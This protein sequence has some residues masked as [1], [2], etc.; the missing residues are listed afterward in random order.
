MREKEY[1]WNLRNFG[2]GLDEKKTMCRC[3][4]HTIW[5]WYVQKGLLVKV[6]GLLRTSFFLRPR[7]EHSYI[8]INTHS[9]HGTCIFTWM[10]DFYGF[11]VGKYTIH[12]SYGIR[13]CGSLWNRGCSFHGYS[14]YILILKSLRN[15]QNI[16]V[17]RRDIWKAN[18]QPKSETF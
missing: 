2:F 6:C 3:F 17:L 8:I 5:E 11:H 1:K 18:S 14:G 9:I 16:W 12:G 13:N 7:F 4:F 10:V 15:H